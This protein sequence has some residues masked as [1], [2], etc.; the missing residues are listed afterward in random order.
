LKG[1]HRKTIACLVLLLQAPGVAAAGLDYK[2]GFSLVDEQRYAPGFTHFNYLNPNA[3]KG[4]RLVLSTALDINNFSDEWDNTVAVAPGMAQTYDVLLVRANDELS[5]YYGSVAEGI[6]VSEDLRSIAFRLRPE[7]RWHDSRPITAHDVKFTYDFAA[8][9]N[10]GSLIMDW[11]DSVEIVDEREVLF[12]LTEQLTT[13]NLSL[14]GYTRILP[15]HYWEGGDPTE[16]TMIPPLGSGPY[17]VADFE[18]GSFIR[19]ERVCDYWGKDLPINKGRYN[20]DEIRYEVYRD[21]TV[22]REALRKG[23]FDAFIEGDIRHWVSSYNVPARDEGRLILSHAAN[24]TFIGPAAVVAFN[25]RKAPFDEPGVREALSLAMDYM[26]LNRVVNHG[27]LEQA[28]SYFANSVFAATG[29]PSTAELELL[30][31]YRDEIPRRVFT[32]AFGSPP[33]SGVG[34]NRDALLQA[35]ELLRQSGYGIRDGVLVDGNGRPFEIEFLSSEVAHR[36]ILLPYIESLKVLGIEARIRLVESAQLIN[37]RRSFDFDAMIH[38]LG[39][40]IP[41][42]LMGSYYLHSAAANSPVTG[43]VAG[44]ADPV[45]DALLARG[46]TATSLAEMVAASQALD[47][48]LLW[49]FYHVL[50]NANGEQRIVHW[51]KFGRADVGYEHMIQSVFPEGWWYDQARAERIRGEPSAEGY[52]CE[53]DEG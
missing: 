23:L 30:S 4:G 49:N 31:P 45:V 52:S 21:G 14:F 36:R 50:L 24:G 48:V 17:R 27:H 6:A 39:L 40:M 42:D 12:R 9:T 32:E 35:R 5:G 3:P 29:L 7:A 10:D 44:I 1:P 22:A 11:L 19:Y 46:G 18:Q 15:A 13:A 33:S 34:N 28:T 20:F 16:T 41:P 25:I 43:N 8:T 53:G 26:W 2:H 47:R 37:R 51:D 38:G